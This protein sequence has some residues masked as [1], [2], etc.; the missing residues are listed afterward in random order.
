MII[1]PQ[2]KLIANLNKVGAKLCSYTTSEQVV[3][4]CDCKY[5]AANVGMM[6]E[7][8]SGCPEV[9]A[10]ASLLSMLSSEEYTA[11]AQRAGASIL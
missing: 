2:D 9:R 11:L 10:A 3:A 4:R 1:I 7:D 6:T 8:G 5:G